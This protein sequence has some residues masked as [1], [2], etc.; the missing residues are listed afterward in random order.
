[1]NQLKALLPT[2]NME[3]RDKWLSFVNVSTFKRCPLPDC[4]SSNFST[5]FSGNVLCRTLSTWKQLGVHQCCGLFWYTVIVP[6]RCLIVRGHP[7][8]LSFL[9]R[10][11]T[12]RT[13]STYLH[14]C[15][16]SAIAA[17][18]C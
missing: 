13:L 5:H 18:G 4:H 12:S 11:R 3:I 15:V 6:V 2:Y 17:D 10:T 8:V 14:C 9:I 7:P 1:M 16:K